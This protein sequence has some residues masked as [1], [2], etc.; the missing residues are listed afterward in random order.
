M[1]PNPVAAARAFALVAHGDQRYGEYPFIVHLEDVAER[2]FAC[3]LDVDIITAA[4][5]HD[6]LE[7]TQTPREELARLFGEKVTTL[8]E[9]VT[10]K[11][12]KNRA[13]RHAATY[14]A[15]RDNPSALALKLCDRLANTASCYEWALHQDH[16]NTKLLK[17]YA[18]EY[19]EFRTLLY[20]DGEWPVLWTALDNLMARARE[21]LAAR[22]RST[23]GR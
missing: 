7:D 20:R 13:A 9:A 4:Y 22:S 10:N 23:D 6:V 3:G 8:V 18:K 19:D 1:T 15:L 16:R 2:A 11:P 14:P 5:L 17:M 12:G 21:L